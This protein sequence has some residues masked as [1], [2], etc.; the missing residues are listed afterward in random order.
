VIDFIRSKAETIRR[1]IMIAEAF[2]K[3]KRVAKTQRITL[4]SEYYFKGACAGLIETCGFVPNGFI[5][6]T[7]RLDLERRLILEENEKRLRE[8]RERRSS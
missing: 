5:R 3:L 1:R 6:D 2:G 8:A 7:A 4:M